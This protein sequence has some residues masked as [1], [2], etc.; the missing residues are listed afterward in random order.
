MV[1]VYLLEVS[2][3]E[4][5]THNL[6]GARLILCHAAEQMMSLMSQPAA[7][8]EMIERSDCSGVDH[9]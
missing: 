1:V 5:K 4:Q 8:L 6:E 7:G 9:S 3:G 2:T